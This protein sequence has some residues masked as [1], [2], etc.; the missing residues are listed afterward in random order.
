MKDESDGPSP[1]LSSLNREEWLNRVESEFVSSRAKRAYYMVALR[2][3]WPED[4][5]GPPF[6]PLDLSILRPAIDERRI[7]LK[8]AKPGER[9]LDAP[10]RMREIIGEEKLNIRKKGRGRVVTY[11]LM[12]L[13]YIDD[14]EKRIPRSGCPPA[15]WERVKRSHKRRCAVC[16]KHEDELIAKGWIFEPDHKRPRLRGGGDEESNWQ[17]LCTECNNFKSTACRGCKLDCDICP[18]AYPRKFAQIQLSQ[19]N[20]IAMRHKALE[21]DVSAS[22]L[23]NDIITTHLGKY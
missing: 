15:M 9:Y 3:L 13:D 20:L 10:R 17:P 14:G 19:D 21:L 16:E 23:L 8:M 6:P 11:Q 5:E 7:V 1:P 22:V 18:W 4:K 12:G 2:L